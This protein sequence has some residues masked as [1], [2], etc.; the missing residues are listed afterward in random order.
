MPPILDNISSNLLEV[1]E[2]NIP[3]H[4]RAQ[5][6]TSEEAHAS[7]EHVS[8][9]LSIG[10]RD[11][12]AD[13]SARLIGQLGI[14]TPVDAINQFLTR[15]VPSESVLEGAGPDSSGNRG[16]NGGTNTGEEVE[17]GNDGRNMLMLEGRH[18]GHLSGKHDGPTSKGNEDLRHD[19]VPEVLLRLAEL[20]HEAD[21]EHHE[22]DG[23]VAGDPLEAAGVPDGIAE[24][25][26]GEA[27]ADSVDIGDVGGLLDAGVPD[28]HEHGGEVGAPD[29]GVGED[30]GEHDAAE[31]D[32]AVG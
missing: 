17:D 26:A 6:S 14:Q 11:V 15:E 23:E 25:E 10:K 5:Q 12:M 31:E 1:L 22:G 16:A 27:G 20:D 21:A 30:E 7:N 8:L 9:R 13:L 29:G 4:E 32:G 3:P 19:D 2:R 24:D 18:H 28:D